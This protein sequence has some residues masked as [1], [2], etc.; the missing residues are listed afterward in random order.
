ME[1][2][3]H[4]ARDPRYRGD[5]RG[6]PSGNMRASDADREAMAEILRRHYAAGRLDAE[7]FEERI[8]QCLSAKRL[9]DLDGLLTDLP[10]EPV[11]EPPRERDRSSYWPDWGPGRGPAV[12]VPIVVALIAACALIHG[13]FLGI[14]LLLFLFFG[15]FRWWRH[16][17]RGERRSAS[18][19]SGL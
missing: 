19:G 17:W 15:P 1:S 18:G 9:S 3:T 16:G 2:Q 12:I 13:H 11:P 6:G 14:L 4:G 5:A 10:R 7:E 8:A